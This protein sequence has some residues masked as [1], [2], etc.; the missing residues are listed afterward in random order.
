MGSPIPAAL[1]SL[2]YIRIIFYDGPKYMK[3]RE[4]WKLTTFIRCYNIYQVL[5]CCFFIWK[6]YSLGFT[7]KRTF[8]SC[9][10]LEPEN[11][12]EL[13]DYFWWF[14]MLRV[15][16]YIE[17]VTFVLRKKF[18]Q[19]SFLH[20]YHHVAIVVMSWVLF[21]FVFHWVIFLGVILNS[22]VHVVMYAYY[23]MSS[24]KGFNRVG[25]K[26]KPFLT[27][28]QIVQLVVFFVRTVTAFNQPECNYSTVYFF[29]AAFFNALLIILFTNFFIQAYLKKRNASKVEAKKQK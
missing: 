23:F 26:L 9:D 29:L 27:A 16:E 13:A 4:P 14:I 17:T 1:I 25:G 24:F 28:V 10:S 2:I 21:T 19:I 7:F 20:V 5:A 11:F 3:N 8:Q 6:F 18:N 12:K 15:S 22:M